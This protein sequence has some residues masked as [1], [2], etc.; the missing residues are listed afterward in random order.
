MKAVEISV[1]VEASQIVE[2]CMS[3]SIAEGEHKC[4]FHQILAFLFRIYASL[5]IENM[6]PTMLL[7]NTILNVK[8]QVTLSGT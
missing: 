2:V 1:E 4:C 8:L 5:W 7:Y 6:V 3:M